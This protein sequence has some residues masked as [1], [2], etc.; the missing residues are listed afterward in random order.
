MKAKQLKDRFEL[1][2]VKED[3]HYVYIDIKPILAK[4]KQEFQQLRLA[5]YGPGPKT[6]ELAYL[7]GAGLHREAE[8]RDGTVEDDGAEGQRSGNYGE[9]VPVRERAR[10]PFPASSRSRAGPA[11]R[12]GQPTP[13]VKGRP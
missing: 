13:P 12:P 6:G 8:R 3:E 7:P 9:G 1:K 10:V 5:L 2:L 11:V 4:D